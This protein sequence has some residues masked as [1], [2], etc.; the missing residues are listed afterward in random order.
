MMEIQK[1]LVATIESVADNLIKKNLEGYDTTFVAKV[2]LT[3]PL[4][5]EYS[6]QEF[7]IKYVSSFLQPIAATLNPGDLVLVSTLG[8]DF[9][10]LY[11]IDKLVE[12]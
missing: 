2:A 11:L 10:S 4:T 5:I 6:S 9:S 7:F 1:S 8:G 3:S 12:P